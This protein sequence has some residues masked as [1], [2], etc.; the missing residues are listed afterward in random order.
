MEHTGSNG[1]PGIDMSRE[2]GRLIEEMIETVDRVMAD[3]GFYSGEPR[4]STETEFTALG[5]AQEQAAPRILKSPPSVL[6]RLKS[7]L[8]ASLVRG[9]LAGGAMP[10]YDDRQYRRAQRHLGEAQVALKLALELLK[11]ETCTPGLEAAVNGLLIAKKALFMRVVEME[12][13]RNVR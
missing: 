9:N 13:E 12:A 1:N 7:I 4:E 5:C 11:A 3:H 8:G 2:P 6:G 10:H